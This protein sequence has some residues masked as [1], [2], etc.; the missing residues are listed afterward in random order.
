MEHSQ[1]PSPPSSHQDA[2]HTAALGAS[3]PVKLTVR[4]LGVDLSQGF[5][6][7]WNGGDAFLT[8]YCNALSMSFPTG[9]QFFVDAVKAGLKALPDTPANAAL[10]ETAKGFIGQEATHR[11]L[12]A[13]YNAHLLKQGFQNAWELR[14]AKRIA[15]AHQDFFSKSDKPYLHMLAVTAA[16]EHYTAIFGD[17]SLEDL[18][19]PGDMF[20]HAEEPLKTLWRWHAAEESEHKTVAFDLYQSLGGNHTWRLRWFTYVSI[21]FT[22]DIIRQTINNLWHDKTL[23]KPST[24]WSALKFTVGPHGLVWRVAKPLLAY[25]RKDFHPNDVGS[26]TAAATWLSGHADRWTPVGA[27]ASLAKAPAQT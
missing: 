10:R 1:T 3:N 27:S 14:A 6:R 8:A 23:H 21:Q 2:L 7:H 11:H 17:L 20:A 12:H 19:G 26:A 5:S 15:K 16:F 24:W 13:L 9:E 25:R 18:D 22:L 4:R